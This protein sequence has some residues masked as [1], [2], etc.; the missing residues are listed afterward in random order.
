MGANQQTLQ[1]D[2]TEDHYQFFSLIRGL[3]RYDPNQRL[4]AAKALKVCC[5]CA[6]PRCCSFDG[7]HRK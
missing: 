5:V 7:S 6:V 3:L 1:T 4:T 2:T